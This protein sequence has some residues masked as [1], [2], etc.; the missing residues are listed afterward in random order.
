MEIELK[1]AIADRE[2][3][4]WSNGV[5]TYRKTRDKRETD[6]K[7]LAT[8]LLKRHVGDEQTIAALLKDYETT[9]TGGRRIH[10]SYDGMSDASAD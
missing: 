8:E 4:Q 10:F 7:S 5:L 3:L 6:W 1:A 9:K 2:G